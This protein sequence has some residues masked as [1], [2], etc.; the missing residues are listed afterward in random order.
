MPSSRAN[1]YSTSAGPVV[2]YVQALQLSQNA[3]AN[4]LPADVQRRRGE[5][6]AWPRDATTIT[7]GPPEPGE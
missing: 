2:S 6:G 3:P 4:T 5:V 7:P 1:P